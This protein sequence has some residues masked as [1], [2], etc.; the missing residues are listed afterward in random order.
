M[1]NFIKIG[2]FAAFAT[3]AM[4]ACVGDLDVESIDPN[5]VSAINADQLLG[6]IYATLGTTG[7]QGPAGNGDIEGLDEGTSSLYRMTYELNEFPS[8]QV[9]WIWPDVGVDD[10]RLATWTADNALVRGAYCR[11][12]FDITLCNEYLKNY[13][14]YDAA[15]TAEVRF[16]RALNYWYLLDMFGSCPFNITADEMENYDKKTELTG[17]FDNYPKQISRLNL[18][19]WIESE[20]LDIEDKLTVDRTAFYYRVDAVAAQMLLARLY[21]NAQVY[22]ADPNQ[23]YALSTGTPEWDKAASYA[24]KVMESTTLASKYQYLFMGDN[25]SRSLV[26]DAYKEIILPVAQEGSHI[27][28]YGASLFLLASFNTDGLPSWGITTSWKCMRT[29]KQL[30]SLFFPK[31]KNWNLS[32]DMENPAGKKEDDK[33]VSIGWFTTNEKLMKEIAACPNPLGDASVLTKEAGDDRALFCNY[34]EYNDSSLIVCN[35]NR[36]NASDK[37]FAGWLCTKFTNIM[38]D[39][40]R[41]PTNTDQPD[42]DLPLMR[43]AEAYLTYAEAQFR[44]G[45]MNDALNVLNELRARAN[46]VALTDINENVIRDEWGREFY[47]EGRRR[48]DLVRLGMF[49]GNSYGWEWKAGNLFGQKPIEEHRVVFP[50]PLSDITANPN[51]K[52]Y[53]NLY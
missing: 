2:I 5:N 11:Y 31:A 41:V 27:Q 21:L 26:N 53:T 40:S 43:A 38:A 17:E 47:A 46:A 24:K 15:K 51:L 35:L 4:T 10:V 50:I 49:V 25:D 45:E 23:L 37:F 9:F 34:R 30:V 36:E 6:K 13:S 22:T 7:Q 8:D 29:R 44:N 52:Q 33:V 20:L 28:S 3:L 1:K 42:M 32:E 48:T 14:D 18:Y 12:I 16:I 19:K 39:P